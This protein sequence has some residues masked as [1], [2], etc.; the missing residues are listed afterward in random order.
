[1]D[2][3]SILILVNIIVHLGGGMLDLFEL[4][5][6]QNEIYHYFR[7]NY[8]LSKSNLLSIVG[9]HLGFCHIL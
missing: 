5:A 7:R 1:M 6:K 8:F 9:S 4:Y 2:L 3:I